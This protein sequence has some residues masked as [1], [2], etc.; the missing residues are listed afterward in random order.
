MR[1]FMK[2]PVRLQIPHKFGKDQLISSLYISF[3]EIL[4]CICKLPQLMDLCSL[5]L[6][7]IAFVNLDFIGE[8]II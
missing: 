2:Q 7:S 6:P 3:S 4:V 5:P 8:A 1:L